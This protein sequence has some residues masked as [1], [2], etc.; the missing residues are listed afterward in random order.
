M[1]TPP[2]D[3]AAAFEEESS[4]LPRLSARGWV[5]VSLGLAALIGITAW[6]AVQMQSQP[7]RWKDVGFTVTSPTE[8]TATYE[9]YLYTD[10]G[11]TC[12]VRALNDR[13]TEVGVAA[14]HVDRAD[15]AE[16]RLTTPVVT[17]EEATTATVQGCVAD[18]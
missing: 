12:T 15:G 18:G 13:F 17:T 3:E 1:S 11:A 9:V 5:L 6:V 4:A 16:Q 8:V 14:V 10:A 7:V 2:A